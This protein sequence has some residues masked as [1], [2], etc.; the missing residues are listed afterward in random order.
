M[1]LQGDPSLKKS[2]TAPIC[3]THV[4]MAGA[5]HFSIREGLQYFFCSRSCHERF[6]PI[7][8]GS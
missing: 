3:G 7:L 5:K 6:R 1:D 4:E 8:N 2:A